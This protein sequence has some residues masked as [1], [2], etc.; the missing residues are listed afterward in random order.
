MKRIGILICALALLLSSCAA[1]AAEPERME[2]EGRLLLAENGT[3]LLVTEDRTPIA[4]SVQ[5]EGNDPWAGYRSGDR[6][7]VTHDGVNETY[8]AQTRAYA[9][10]QLEE[11]T[12]EDIPE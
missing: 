5:A 8:P 7:R 1:P 6:I 2:T 12:L 9:W 11:G 4:L 10:E 3:A